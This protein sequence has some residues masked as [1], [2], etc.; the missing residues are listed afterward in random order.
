MLALLDTRANLQHH[1]IWTLGGNGL[2][3]AQRYYII[4]QVFIPKI[5][6]VI[7]AIIPIASFM[8][9]A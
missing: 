2:D 3:Y 5:D 6:S 9:L 8:C 4:A 7:Q 1:A